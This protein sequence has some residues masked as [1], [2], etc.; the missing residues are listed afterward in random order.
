V[1]LLV[2]CG[3]FTQ[4]TQFNDGGV[5]TTPQLIAGS[6]T[7]AQDLVVHG[8]FVYWVEQGTAA[9]ATR[10]GQ[11]LRAPID[12]CKD[13]SC[14]QVMAQNVYSPAGIT[15]SLDGTTLFYSE[16][17]DPTTFANASG[18]IW[19]IS[20]GSDETP[21][22][23]ADKQ[24]EPRKLA[25]DETA[26]YW[27]NAAN[28][29][30]TSSGDVHRAWLDGSSQGAI[31]TGRPSPVEISV[32]IKN[33]NVFWTEFGTSEFDGSLMSADVQGNNLS[34]LATA[35]DQPRGLTLGS[36]NVYWANFGNGTVMRANQDGTN[37]GAF[38][39]DRLSPSDVLISGDW[40][41]VAESGSP[42]YYTDGRIVAMK[43]D[44]TDSKILADS[45]NNP[46][47]LAMDDKAVYWV[48][49]GTIMT[50]QYDASVM[51]VAKP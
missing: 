19:Q 46:R 20:L 15:I 50:D 13:N 41:L 51:R 34:E 17:E 7:H 30:G 16:Y 10:D 44:G 48:N 4:Q 22:L 5:P 37:V 29:D 24:G 39:S 28:D 32:D 36:T 14:P 43:L 6:R 21:K 42:P 38:A 33:A 2:G 11:V 23:F 31:V 27:V 25:V 26:L 9:Q 12:G 8:G 18:R 49:A 1:L 47:S 3:G 40:L 35:Q 45:Q